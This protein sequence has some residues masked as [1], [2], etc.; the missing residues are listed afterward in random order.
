MC[1]DGITFRLSKS[2]QGL[3]LEGKGNLENITLC[4]DMFL[5]HEVLLFHTPVRWLLKASFRN[6][7]FEMKGEI[8]LVSELKANEFLFYISGRICLKG[9][10]YLIEKFEKVNNLNLKLQG[11]GT[12]IIQL[13]E[14]TA[15]ILFEVS[16]LAW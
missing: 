16:K 12:N 2:V 11:K 15:N 4:K 9:F 10:A 14:E 6:R 7:V 3:G 1:N 5:A 13:R 8:K